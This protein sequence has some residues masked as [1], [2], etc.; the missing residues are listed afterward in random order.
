MT[1]IEHPKQSRPDGKIFRIL[2]L[3]A[4]GRVE[5]LTLICTELGHEVV[6][7]LTIREGVDFMDRQDHVDVIVSAAHLADESVFDF[8]R[9]I[10]SSPLHK[11]VPFMLICAE[12]G[13]LGKFVNTVV[14]KAA[15]V[16]GAAKYVV[17]EPYD[18]RRLMREIHALLP[19]TIPLKDQDP[20]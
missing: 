15:T 6:P 1:E 18:A 7:V 11:E 2:V 9:L 10:K 4:P 5:E 13:E 8:L 16:L 19:D 14:E 3:D 20:A 17:M 12:P